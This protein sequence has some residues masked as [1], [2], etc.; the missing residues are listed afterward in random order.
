MR[1]PDGELRKASGEAEARSA[2]NL[3][4]EVGAGARPHQGRS[5]VTLTRLDSGLQGKNLCVEPR[6]RLTHPPPSGSHD[7]QS[8]RKH[9]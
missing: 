6:C 4:S 8:G 9:R 5:E 7:S 2:G 1:Q 3:Y